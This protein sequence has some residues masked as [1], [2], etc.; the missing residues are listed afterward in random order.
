MTWVGWALLILV[1]WGVAGVLLTG[2]KGRGS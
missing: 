2:R 1:V